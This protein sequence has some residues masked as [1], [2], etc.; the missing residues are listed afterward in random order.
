[1]KIPEKIKT[2]CPK[3]RKHQE[4]RAKQVHERGRSDRGMAKGNRKHKRRTEGYTSRIGEKA[5][6]V[7]QSRKRKILLECSECGNKKEKKY[8]R[9]RK[10]IEIER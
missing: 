2:Y 9:S 4:H 8:P 6:S 1:M 5:D 7:K 3:C 10:K